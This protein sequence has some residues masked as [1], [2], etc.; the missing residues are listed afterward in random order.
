MKIDYCIQKFTISIFVFT[1]AWFM[2]NNVASAAI[3]TD[4]MPVNKPWNIS[5]QQFLAEYGKDDTSKAIINYYFKNHKLL[6]KGLNFFIPASALTSG[7]ALSGTNSPGKAI[8]IF[9]AIIIDDLTLAIIGRMAKYS[10]KKL[11]KTLD[12]YF[13]GKGIKPKLKRLLFKGSSA[14]RQA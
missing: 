9:I 7:I 2:S 10:R 3:V 13:S 14:Y 5:Q 6:R 1:N 8:F 4:S 11:L 12:N